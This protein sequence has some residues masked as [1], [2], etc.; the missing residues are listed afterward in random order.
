MANRS[1]KIESLRDQLIGTISELRAPLARRRLMLLATTS[2]LSILMVTAGFI[3]L[4]ELSLLDSGQSHEKEPS[5]ASKIVM[6]AW[7]RILPNAK[8]LK[9]LKPL[10]SQPPPRL[11]VK[12]VM[13]VLDEL[14]VVN[15]PRT[16]SESQSSTPPSPVS[17]LFSGLSS[18]LICGRKSGAQGGG[19]LGFDMAIDIKLANRSPVVSAGTISG[20]ADFLDSSGKIIKVINSHPPANWQA[21]ANHS[22]P[23]QDKRTY[24]MH[25]HTFKTLYFRRPKAGGCFDSVKVAARPDSPMIPPN[26]DATEEG[27]SKK[28]V[29]EKRFSLAASSNSTDQR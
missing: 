6:K 10:V 27:A 20:E 18:S 21:T 13:T 8:I 2:C 4:G 16:K 19:N 11:K 3:W 26:F 22:S 23:D 9:K 29:I 12:N 14:E 5:H 15:L 25:N 7:E 1:S 24:R 28:R 17:I